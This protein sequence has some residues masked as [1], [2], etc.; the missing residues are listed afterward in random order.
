[1]MKMS[2]PSRFMAS[3]SRWMRER[4]SWSGSFRAVLTLASSCRRPRFGNA[5]PSSVACRCRWLRSQAALPDTHQVRHIPQL[6]GDIAVADDG[7]VVEPAEQ[8]LPDELLDRRI[9]FQDQRDIL[10]GDA[11]L[12]VQGLPRDDEHP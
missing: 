5:C 10:A 2:V 7:V 4:N 8:D 1:M 6:P 3:R 11:L 12:D 9:R